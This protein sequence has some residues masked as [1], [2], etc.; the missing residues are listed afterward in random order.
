MEFSPFQDVFLSSSSGE[1]SPS[2]ILERWFLSLR[3]THFEKPFYAIP[4]F[5]SILQVDYSLSTYPSL[6]SKS[7]P[8]LPEEFFRKETIMEILKVISNM[9]DEIIH[10]KEHFK[11]IDKIKLLNSI[12][13]ILNNF[14]LEQLK[15]PQDEL[16]RRIRR[17]IIL[18]SVFGILNELSTEEIKDFDEMVKRRPLFK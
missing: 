17:V 10:E 16:L 3:G 9:I 14:T 2:E 5:S 6:E 1:I 15:I 18:E 12:S 13:G 7:E 11:K 8:T 4:N